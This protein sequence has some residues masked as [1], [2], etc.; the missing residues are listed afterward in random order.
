ML[1]KNKRIFTAKYIKKNERNVIQILISNSLLA[2]KRFGKTWNLILVKKIRP[3][4][5]IRL[6]SDKKILTNSLKKQLIIWFYLL[7][8]ICSFCYASIWSRSDSYRKIQNIPL[9]LTIQSNVTLDQIFSFQMVSIDNIYKQINLLNSKKT[10][11]AWWNS[12]QMS[13]PSLKE[14]APIIT[15]IW[16]EEVVASSLNH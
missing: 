11:Y 12:P 3:P 16:N 8:K 4:K 15:K 10:R 7:M 14:S 2:I 13:K 5:K 6:V 9:I 1:K